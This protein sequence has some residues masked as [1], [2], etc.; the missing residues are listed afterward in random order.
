M[1]PQTP[2]ERALQML[3]G[4]E[5]ARDE[6]V[7]ALRRI[8][9]SFPYAGSIR[10]DVTGP[11]V[12]AAFAGA[13]LVR[14]RLA[15]GLVLD[16]HAGSKIT[17]DFILSTPPEPDHV[18]EPQTTRLLL[19]L[20]EGVRHVVIGGAYFGDHALLIAQRLLA[21][22]GSV[23][24]FEPNEQNV[25]LLAHNAELNRL[26][27]VRAHRK[28][29]WDRAT[30]LKLV[31]DDALAASGEMAAGDDPESAFD[32]V[33]IDAYR[34]GLDAD[35]GLVMLDIEGGELKALMGARG[36]LSRPPASAPAVVFEIHSLYVDW[37]R[38]LE[39]TPVVEYLAGLGYRIYAVRDIHSNHDLG[40]HPIE[41][42]PAADVYLEGPPHGFNMLAVKDAAIVG[43]P[44]FRICHHVS[45]KY[46]FH[47]D[48]AL[49]HPLK[50]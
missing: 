19:R 21:A 42:I 40:G 3:G 10:E 37:S 32:T 25:R 30:R 24:C 27:N 47:K 48:P 5:G 13:G 33:T 8:E 29:L 14:K 46:L 50:A 41:L 1:H 28:G 44:L 11:I 23:H 26:T 35:V 12:D 6:L 31:G 45:P 49:Y 9:A 39:R 22:Q 15:S 43:D 4:N 17:R 34:R 7:G 18:W 2:L 38:G 20:A 36:E 16:F